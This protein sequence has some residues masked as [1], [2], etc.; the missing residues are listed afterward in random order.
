[1][2]AARRCRGN[3]HKPS[4]QPAEQRHQTR[5]YTLLLALHAACAVCC[6]ADQSR[7][8]DVVVEQPSKDDHEQLQSACTS[9]TNLPNEAAI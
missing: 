8:V 1:L 7:N 4:D 3:T 6:H 5:N 9:K 2:D